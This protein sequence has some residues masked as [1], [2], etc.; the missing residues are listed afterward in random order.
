MRHKGC[1]DKSVLLY[2]R[3]WIL[4]LVLHC[5]LVLD[6]VETVV[7]KSFLLEEVESYLGPAEKVDEVE[8]MAERTIGVKREWNIDVDPL[9]LVAFLLVVDEEDYL[10]AGHNKGSCILAPTQMLFFD[11][12]EGH[13]DLEIFSLLLKHMFWLNVPE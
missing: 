8:R 13:L 12:F 2:I 4:V 3:Q 11:L 9:Y 7:D 6:D 10:I 5:L 1:Q